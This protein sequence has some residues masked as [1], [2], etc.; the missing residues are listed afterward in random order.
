MSDFEVLGFDI[1]VNDSSYNTTIQRLKDI[2]DRLNKI[3]KLDKKVGGVS[4]TGSSSKAKMTDEEKWEK[5]YQ[6]RLKKKEYYL[7]QGY[8]KEAKI[9]TEEEKFRESFEKA[10]R[11]KQYGIDNG[12]I[13]EKQNLSEIE[14]YKARVAKQTELVTDAEYA[15]VRAKEMLNQALKTQV[16]YSAIVTNQKL[17]QATVDAELAKIQSQNVIQ[18]QL[19]ANADYQSALATKEKNK[20]L[21]QQIT[22]EARLQAERAALD[23]GD[24]ERIRRQQLENEQIKKNIELRLRQELGIKS[25]T[26]SLGSYIAKLTSVVMVARRFA[27][28]MSAAVKESAAYIESLNL[29]AVAFGNSYKEQLD[30][31]LG[32]AEAYG[33]ANNEVLKFAGTFRELASSLGLVGETADLVSETVTKLGYDLAALFNTSVEQAMEK[34]QSGVF[35]GNVRPLRSFGI[36]ISQTQIDALIDSTE[37]L[38]ELG[39]SAKAMTQADK[40]IA[41]LIITLR[42]GKDSF[43]TMAREINN[44]QSQFRIFEGSL[45][46]FK[47]AIGDLI[48]QPLS[49]VMVLV[50]AFIIALTDAIRVFVPLQKDD[51]T[52]K[53]ILNTAL[54]A[55]EANE[56]LDELNSKLAS[57]DKFN[58]LQQSSG[59]DN[60]IALTETLNRLLEEEVN[61]YDTE[62]SAAMER[63]KNEAV[64]LSKKIKDVV[65]ISVILMG[66]WSVA[67]LVS[68]V[69]TM[70]LLKQALETFTGSVGNLNKGLSGTNILLVAGIIFAFYK[71]YE[72]IQKGDTA[73]AV[74]AGTIG[75]VL[76][77]ALIK[78][79]FHAKQTQVELMKT[80]TA[81][82][83][84]QYAMLATSTVFMV[85]GLS[86]LL[87][88]EMSAGDKLTHTFIGLAAAIGAAAIAM[89][90]FKQNWVEAFSIAA[91]VAG[92]YFSIASMSA[93]ADG[94]YTNANLIMTHENGKREWVGKAAGSSAIV[95][96]TQ[97]S[98][99]MEMAVAKGVYNALSARSAMGSGEST[100]E[101]IVVKI[102]EEEVFNAVR[103]TAKRQGK[104][105]ANA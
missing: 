45:A 95:N 76:V 41:R 28:F 56:Q 44:L 83:G 19:L 103:K 84:L 78:F 27:Q 82:T 50:N 29:F 42:S 62:L 105:F 63:M 46:N 73:T 15:E 87:S 75:T 67:K 100:N 38:K 90:F 35:S 6:D 70:K 13:T 18:S 97:M 58:V 2:E 51:E 37:A 69:Q 57:F 68:I 99:I 25:N 5:Q 54:G 1:Q 47:L 48:E 31:A 32:I 16:S 8:I 17:R 14:K 53:A 93:H 7:K 30:W 3:K 86:S 4:G 23:S 24:Y 72:A 101:T 65:V 9:L 64:E 22:S 52:P 26:K 55:E 79:N 20:Y 60:N 89:A 88:S 66:V 34:L 36:D 96:D 12:Y 102:G 49:R 43:G 61:L 74:I 33:L 91:T 104:D 85:G 10:K 59:A 39:V 40:T 94:G 80:K 98:D 71:M 81:V 11:K 77:G 92:G 21:E